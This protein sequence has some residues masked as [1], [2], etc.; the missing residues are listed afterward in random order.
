MGTPESR[1][2][3]LVA[4]LRIKS[5][6]R[7]G[8]FHVETPRS[9]GG[10]LTGIATDLTTRRKVLVT[11]LHVMTGLTEAG[12]FQ[13]PSGTEQMYHPTVDPDGANL[14][15]SRL[16]Y[17]R[18][19]AVNQVDMAT[20]DRE[21]GVR[22][23]QVLHSEPTHTDRKI[24]A[25]TRKPLLDMELVMMGGYGGEGVVTVE[26]VGVNRSLGGRR[27]TN[28]VKLDCGDRPFQN[29]DSGAGCYLDVGDGNYR[30]VCIAMGKG[31]RS[32]TIGW[33]FPAS[34]AEA[35]MKIRF[36]NTPPVAEAGDTQ[37]ADS[38]A[39]VTLDGS[40]S[41][42]PD[43]D[44]L[45]YAWEQIPVDG[46]S[47]VNLTG[48]N[49]AVASFVAPEGLTVLRFKLTV[50]D[51]YGDTDDDRATVEVW[52]E[53]TD[54]GETSGDGM[55]R[56]KEQRRTS[57]FGDAETR[58]VSDPATYE[59]PPPE[60]DPEPDVED[61]GPWVDTSDTTGSLGDRMRKQERW[62]MLGNTQTRW[63]SDP[64]PV[65]WGS[66]RRTGRTQGSGGAREA[67][68]NRLSNYGVYE[69]RWVPDPEEVVET[70]GEWLDTG[71][72][73]YVPDIFEWEKRQQRNSNLG[74]SQTRWTYSHTGP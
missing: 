15:G 18:L 69:T 25:G 7:P 22:V 27:F 3:E 71:R 52:G 31:N 43:Y 50:T 68:E 34:T 14:M 59:P 38:F 1:H 57:A 37:M 30:L 13:V 24:V 67:E 70:W 46:G 33:A 48:A 74:N 32:G 2:D 23:D 60:P 16:D 9:G 20:C 63:V 11:N 62:S 58:W 61:W 36:G 17:Y 10:T 12:N 29:G 65:T 21:V 42:D 19:G 40:A 55:T 54:T 53:W 8:A 41:S 44:T 56:E 4:G 51:E 39:T 72:T 66:W 45:T 5:G 49:K 47:S 35:S 26:A 6:S 28:L 64:E 73:R